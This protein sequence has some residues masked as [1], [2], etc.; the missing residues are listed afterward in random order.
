MSRTN[1]ASFFMARPNIASFF[2]ARTNIA[3]FFSARSQNSS[4]M[5][6]HLLRAPPI[7][8]F[9]IDFCDRALRARPLPLPTRKL[10]GGG[11][12]LL[13]R[14]GVLKKGSARLYAKKGYTPNIASFF[15]CRA[16]ILHRFL[17]ART[18]IASFF[19]VAHQYCIVFLVRGHKIRHRCC[20]IYYAH[21]LFCHFASI[22]V[23]AH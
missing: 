4:S 21:P 9:C 6:H 17:M 8:P 10:T 20:I 7:L 22:F 1:I 14:L 19:S 13:L 3:S 23:T 2:M 18:N 5:L 16:L 15:I 11:I 12:P